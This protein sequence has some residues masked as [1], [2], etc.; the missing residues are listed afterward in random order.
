V[1]AVEGLQAGYRRVAGTKDMPVAR[2]VAL[3][4]VRLVLAFLFIWHGARTLFGAFG[5]PG[6]HQASVFYGTIAHLHP[7][8]FFTILSGGTEFFG[9]IAVGLG[10]LGRLGALGIICDMIGAMVTVT[11]ANG[12]PANATAPGG[13]YELN[14][15]LAALALP[16]AVLGTGRLSLDEVLRNRWPRR[17]SPPGHPGDVHHDDRSRQV[18]AS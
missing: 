18:P 8:T 3:L 12:L 4:G 10:V 17:S 6:V 16:V 2:D 14:M 9:G 11:F 7:A 1:T 15:A 5:G 13:G